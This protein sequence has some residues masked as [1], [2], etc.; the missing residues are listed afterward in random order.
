MRFADRKDAGQQ[1]A[2]AVVSAAPE[3]PVVLGLPRGGVPVARE[4]ATALRAPLS[5]LGVR[6][7]GLPGNP[8]FAVGAVAEGGVNVTDD[9][10]LTTLRVSG[11]ELDRIRHDEIEELER[12]VARYRPGPLPDLRG[13]TALIV[14]DGLATGWTAVAAARAAR[15][16]GAARV[17]ICAPVGSPTAIERIAGECEAVVMVASSGGNRAV[18]E[19]YRDFRQVEDDEVCALLDRP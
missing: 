19:S 11:E 4:V 10:A 15:A 16:A 18:G 7:L 14:D 6:K 12:R 9:R 13:R 1:L 3:D 17:W 5:V 8:E 2:A